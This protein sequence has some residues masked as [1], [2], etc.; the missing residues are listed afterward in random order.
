MFENPFADYGSIVSAERF[1]GRMRSLQTIENRVFKPD[2]PGS[3]AIIGDHRI[4]KSSLLY[5]AIIERRGELLQK[6]Q[7]PIW[8][9]LATFDKSST[10][11]R[12]L[13]IRC[14]EELA[15]LDWLNES[16]TRA[17]EGLNDE[18][19]W[20]EGY[21]R[22]QRFFGKLLQSGI[23]VI[24]L[25]DEFDHARYLFKQD[26][27][28][29]QGLRE[30]A[31]RPEWRV[32]F[33][34]ASRRSIR[35][36]EIQTRAISTFDGIFHKHYLGM[37]DDQDFQEYLDRL[38]ALGL[39]INELISKKIEIYC[40]KHPY[41]LAMMGYELVESF[42]ITH[43]VEVETCASSLERSFLD[44]Y[45]RIVDLLAE[46]KSLNKLLQIIFGPL[47]DVT[48]SDVDE[49]LRYGLIHLSRDG[50][51]V[52]FSQNFQTYLRLVERQTELWPIWRE[53]EITLRQL[54][55]SKM[56]EQHGDQWVE[57]IEKARPNLKEVFNQCRTAQRREEN[58]FGTRASRT[59]IDFTYPMDLYAI[60]AAEWQTFR[61]VFGKDKS[62]WGQR[63]QLLGKIR[64]PLAHNRDN[65][66]RDYERQVA[67]GYCKELLATIDSYQSNTRDA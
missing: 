7:L 3:L 52:A 14:A 63:M 10:F 25:L 54:I 31:Y 38:T 6:H 9:N 67:E 45:D 42:R 18:L 21:S 46:D 59:L 19:S 13:V 33:V 23:R 56:V 40:G 41:L 51:Y 5:S 20:T 29:F 35:D 37:F 62:Y 32:A 22:I 4:G 49:F 1:I 24:F 28:G 64:N 58:S 11:F 26:I 53:T 60:I 55:T 47:L 65:I 27:S 50:T 16:I 17:I 36:I 15:E 57:T 12:E 8:I 30:L 43:Q 48:Q 2:I 34:T 39:P 44:Q 66:L 61:P